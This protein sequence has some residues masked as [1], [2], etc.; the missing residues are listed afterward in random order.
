MVYIVVKDLKNNN[1]VF[2]IHYPGPHLKNV[3]ETNV[4][5]R[6]GSITEKNLA[7]VISAISNVDMDNIVRDD[8]FQHYVS[9]ELLNRYFKFSFSEILFFV[10]PNDVTTE[11]YTKH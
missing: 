11:K 4:L 6:P 7:T 10:D 9:P 2:D 8:V 3:L 5:V 1:V